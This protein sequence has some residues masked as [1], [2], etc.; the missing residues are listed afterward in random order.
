MVVV[1]R[2]PSL[3][4]AQVVGTEVGNREASRIQMFSSLET[5]A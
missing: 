3:R 5:R 2:E 1:P 4:S